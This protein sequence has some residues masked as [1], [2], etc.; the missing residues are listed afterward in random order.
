MQ[1]EGRSVTLCTNL[2]PQRPLAAPQRT[3]RQATP[4]ERLGILRRQGIRWG[5]NSS[6]TGHAWGLPRGGV[7]SG[8]T[9]ETA[10]GDTGGL[11]RV[12]CASGLATGDRTIEVTKTWSHERLGIL[13]LKGRREGQHRGDGPLVV[14]VCRRS[15]WGG[16][17]GWDE[18][19]DQG[20][21]YSQADHQ[22]V[23]SVSMPFT[24]ARVDD[25]VHLPRC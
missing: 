6:S 7:S 21:G 16:R 18:R 13:R 24:L 23:P 19:S 9:G 10:G 11:A 5:S 22:V 8:W 17:G 15:S 1:C 3:H 2:R 25:T 12:V 14:S 20:T 4:H